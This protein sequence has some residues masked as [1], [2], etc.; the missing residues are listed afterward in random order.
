MG[1]HL[2][3]KLSASELTPFIRESRACRNIGDAYEL[4]SKFGKMSL[5]F[6]K[7]KYDSCTISFRRISGNGL[8]SVFCDA[9]F[10]N[11][12]IRS[13]V[14]QE[15]TIKTNR[16]PINI[17]RTMISEG[18][19]QILGIAL[20]SSRDVDEEWR[21]VMSKCSEHKSIRIVDGNLIASA[22]GSIKA[23]KINHIVTEPNGAY[24]MTGEKQVDFPIACRVIALEA[25]PEPKRARPSPIM[26]IASDIVIPAKP[27]PLSLPVQTDRLS[28][29]YLAIYT[30]GTTFTSAFCNRWAIVGPGHVKM[31]YRGEY[32]IPLKDVMAGY[33]YIVTIGT[34]R[35]N[36]NGRYLVDIIPEIEGLNK[37]TSNVHTALDTKGIES[38]TITAGSGGSFKLVI[39]RHSSSRGDIAISSITVKL[40]KHIPRNIPVSDV[41]FDITDCERID[42]ENGKV[43][44]FVKKNRSE[45]PNINLFVGYYK[46]RNARRNAEL[47]YCFAQNLSNLNIN[48]FLLPQIK[49]MYFSEYLEVMRRLSDA[50]SINIIANSDVYF[51]NSILLALN[52]PTDGVY[53]LNR[54]EKFGTSLTHYDMLCSSDCWIFKGIP[55]NIFCDFYLGWWGSDGRIGYEIIKAGYK[56]YNPS[57]SIRCIHY[58]ESSIRNWSLRGD[59]VSFPYA[60]AQA[61]TIENLIPG[62]RV[63]FSSEGDCREF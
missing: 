8:V 4:E 5:A 58:H 2:I 24:R 49:R 25:E 40:A 32:T 47:E 9:E 37:W 38:F 21:T 61:C 45:K 42:D 26:T 11:V 12:Y 7:F 60:G 39:G 31:D 20:Y 3:A 34:L 16:N 59:V 30:S 27:I 50:D 28:D 10:A 44:A 54:W 36:G 6:D 62:A 33:S 52:M 41:N 19:I 51:D 23:G 48:T 13:K 63:R 15:V 56:L 29:D 18:G 53:A 46:D 22:G 1:Q 35:I 57:L 43:M 17:V 14:N 55:R